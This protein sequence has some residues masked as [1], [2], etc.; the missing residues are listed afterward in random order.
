MTSE[1]VAMR[2]G[3]K[4]VRKRFE[5]EMAYGNGTKLMMER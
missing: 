3:A 2:N 5:I 4:N 1:I